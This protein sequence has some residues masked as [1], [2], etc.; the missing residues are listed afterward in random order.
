M[1]KISTIFLGI[2]MALSL[3]AC[4]AAGGQS[5][6]GSSQTNS[7]AAQGNPTQTPSETQGESNSET[8]NGGKTLI[9]YYSATSNT[10]AVAEYIAAETNGDLFELV[11]TEPYSSGDLNWTDRNSRV[12]NEHN[13]A[14]LRTVELEKAVPDNWESYDYVF[15]GYPIWWGI[16]AWPVDGFISANDFSGKTVIPFCTSTSSGLGE[17][18]ELL[19]EAAGTGNWL[20][21]E[22][23]RE[24]PSEDTVRDWVRGLGL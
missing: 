2:A 22:R 12:S 10:E 7:N 14:S 13:D 5:G 24:H 17:S 8:S 15:V 9:V 6:T 4:G 23:F 16:A 3:T 21:G 18:G 1:K 11:P 19:K 20:D